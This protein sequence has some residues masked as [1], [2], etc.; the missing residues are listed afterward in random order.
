MTSAIAAID[1]C[2]EQLVAAFEPPPRQT[3]SEWADENRR[4]SSEASAEPGPWRTDRAPYQRAILDALTPNSPYERVVMMAA[5]QTGKTEVALCLVGYIIDRDPGPMLVV[6]PRVEDGEAW[7]KDR[8]APMFRNTPCL[9]GKVA[10]VRSRDSNNRI[11][12]KQFQGGSITI[13]G[14]NSPA[15]LAMRPIRYV[16]L[17]EVDRYPASAGTEGDPVSLAIK[18]SATW[19]NRKILLVSTPT[20]KGASRIESW[21]L[22]SNQSSYW[23]PC[24]ECGA[25][26][27][28][29]W[30][31]LEW[32]EG[33]P[34]EAQYRCAHCGALIPPH[35]KPWMLAHGEWRAANPKSKIAGFWISQLYSPWKEWPETA[36]EFLEAKHGGPETL[37]AFI[38]TALGELWD[39]EA[40]TSVEVATLLNR[41]EVFGARLPAGVALLTAGVDLQVD[42]AELELV[43][44]GRGEESW[45][46]EYRVFPGDPSAPQLWQALDE[47]LKRQWLHEYGISLPVAAC[48]IDSGFHTQ[49]VYD[50]CRTRYHRRIF[51]VKG[52][53]GPLPV[54]P[55]RPS[56]S[57]LGKAPLWIVGVD[58]AKSVIYSRLKI[59]QPGPGYAHFPVERNEEWFEQLLSEVLVTSYAR[60]VPVREWRRKKGVRGEVLDA[61]TY[62]Y[63]ALCGL[64]SMGLR[65]DAEADRMAA[66]R[67]AAEGE[68]RTAAP[69]TV[70]PARKL[71]R[72]RWLESG[73]RR[74]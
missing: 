1:D 29:V 36:A 50:F 41:R 14:A 52:K 39:D 43:G 7:S 44:W 16:L 13:A 74:L 47:Y 12:H 18:R 48:A 30:P 68:E 71:L 67:P 6:L 63:A 17:D 66:L 28:L 40:E 72:S 57:T 42:R 10:D 62:A 45:S 31:N 53:S 4:L 9:N 20:V 11:L 26:Q 49:A 51:A 15:G 59:E 5:S 73:L 65:L 46:I 23:V 27:V 22:R 56:R 54:W 33:Q 24:P 8:L 61:R 69:S 70:T 38:N 58:S 60:G 37:R 25:Y 3:L 34:E 55:K 21:W 35:R 2:I 19:W 32:P 64:V